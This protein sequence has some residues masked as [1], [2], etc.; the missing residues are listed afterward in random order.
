MKTNFK[1][2]TVAL[3]AAMLTTLPASAA[4]IN[5][6][7]N[8]SNGGLL[9]LGGTGT[10][11]TNAVV[12]TGNLLGNSGTNPTA[13][14][15]TDLLGS[16]ANPT[17]ANVNLGGTGNNA[18][19][20]DLFGT[21]NSDPT[22]A[23]VTLG[24]AGNGTSGNAVLDLFGSDGSANPNAT[25]SL[26]SPGDVVSTGDTGRRIDLFGG[27]DGTNGTN[28][29]NETNGT[30][31]SGIFGGNGGSPG[32]TISTGGLR[33]ASVDTRA[34]AC[35][36][37]NAQQIAKLTS[38]HVYEPAT[39]STWS[40]ATS[41]KII[42]AGICD[43]AASSLNSQP[44]IGRLQSYLDSNAPLKAGLGKAGRSPND[45]VA[46]DRNGSDLVVYVM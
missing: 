41:I 44:N 21:G 16:G 2:S 5:L 30:N 18:T 14:A 32:T 31:G 28:G 23:N 34:G 11:N 36:T 19:L 35:F 15:S 7:G 27:G 38:R 4:V 13:N 25:V 39:F 6:G 22:T 43:S 9:D 46:V 1:L 3:L 33:V 45:V 26:G 10:S 42:D 8:G 12:D 24:G 37:P 17:T 40:G 20:L 29:T